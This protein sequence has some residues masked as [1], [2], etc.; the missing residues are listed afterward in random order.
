MLDAEQGPAGTKRISNLVH[1][2]RWEAGLIEE[3][4]WQRADGRVEQIQVQGE[5]ALVIW[6]E[7]VLEKAESLQ[8]EGLCAVRSS[9]AGRLKRIKP[10][11]FNPPGGRPVFVPGFHGLQVLVI[12]PKGPPTLAHLRWWTTRGQ[13]A[14]QAR[15]EEV[16]VFDEVD[17]RW[18]KEVVHI[19]D[20]GFA[21]N[22]WLTQVFVRGARFILGWPYTTISWMNMNNCANPGRSPKANA[23]GI[24]VCSGM[25]VTS[26]NGIPVG[27]PFPSSIPLTLNRSGRW[28][29][30]ASTN[31]PGISSHPNQLIHPNSPGGLSW[32]MPVVGRSKCLSVSTNLN[33]PLKVLVYYIGRRATNSFSSLLSRTLSSSLISLFCLIHLPIGV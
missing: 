4:H 20:R 10:G 27:L 22:P 29:R 8:A 3:F 31:P 23:P 25:P 17:Q 28:W 16:Q 11:Y 18:G 6:D 15:T 33:S 19:W 21:G 14:S 9:K 24:I 5:R 13:A 26:V 30:V 1:S 2:T 12:G 7:S 32:P